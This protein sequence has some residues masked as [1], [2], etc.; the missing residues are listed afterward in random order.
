MRTAGK[1][2][3]IR[4]V[5]RTSKNQKGEDSR[6]RY[7]GLIAN[8]RAECENREEE[9]SENSM[10]QKEVNTVR[11]KIRSTVQGR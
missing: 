2:T 1:K 8:K 6:K 10:R 11:K 4:Q 9:K 3:A 7:E 5:Q